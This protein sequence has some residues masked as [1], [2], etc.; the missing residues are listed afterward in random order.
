MKNE[1]RMRNSVLL[2]LFC[3][4]FFKLRMFEKDNEMIGVYT[5][6]A[7]IIKRA[8]LKSRIF[9]NI[10]FVVTTFKKKVT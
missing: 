4:H 9:M 1:G 5:L 2:Q 6:I 3:V 7:I 10:L 8:L